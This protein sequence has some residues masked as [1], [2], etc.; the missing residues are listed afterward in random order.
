[1][2]LLL[3]SAG[4]KNMSIHNALLELLGK[5]VSEASALFIPTAIYP[6]PAVLAWHGKRSAEKPKAPCANW[7]GSPWECWSFPPSRTPA[8]LICAQTRSGIRTA[9]RRSALI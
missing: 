1:M 5:P 3:T 2:K 6:F 9:P 8:Q 7:V 4:I